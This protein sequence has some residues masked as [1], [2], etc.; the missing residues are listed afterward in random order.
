MTTVLAL[1]PRSALAL[2]LASV[3]GL[4][5]FGWPFLTSATSTLA[6]HSADSPYL[7]LLLLP[8]VVG[9]VLAELSEGGMDAKAVAMLGVLAAAGTALRALSPGTGGLEPTL[10]LVVVAGRVFGAGFGYALG[11]TVILASSLVT[12]G[13]GPWMP[14]Q[15]VGLAWVGLLA[16]L[17]PVVAGRAERV[18]L[19]VYAGVAGFGYGAL[20]NLSF[21]PFS[22]SLPEAMAYVPGDSTAANLRHYAAFYVTT[23][24]GWDCVRALVNA[25]LV[26]V[27][28]RVVLATLRRAARRAAFAA[29]A[30]FDVPTTSRGAPRPRDHAE[31][32]W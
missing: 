7:F 25:A 11:T 4:V 30:G 27:A 9:V 19:A 31:G 21:W 8:L 14:F 26:L 3:V 10:F 12:A 16:G 15:M 24:F 32:D 6:G 5:G 13:V 1:R 28:G 18:L 29:T 17:L 20:L 2:I 23:S 22:R